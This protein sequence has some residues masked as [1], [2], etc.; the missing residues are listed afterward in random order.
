MKNLSI[1]FSF[2]FLFFLTG[3]NA[4]LP[5]TLTA[6]KN[7]EEAG[8]SSEGLKKLDA[9]FQEVI[10]K[11]IAPNIV[12]FIAKKGKIVHFKAFGYSNLETKTALKKDDIFRIASQ[13]KAITTVGLLMLFEEGKFFLDEPI[14]KYIPAFKNPKVLVSYDEK[15][16]QKYI[17]RPA[18]SEITIRQLLSHSAGIPYEHAL[19]NLPEFKVPFYC[20]TEK[21]L[22]KDVVDK[23]AA[24]PLVADPGTKFVYGLNTDVLGR[25]IEILSGMPFDEYL[26]KKVLTPLGMNDTY[27]YLPNSKAPRLVEL[28]SKE[29]RNDDLTV[30]DNDTYR[31][32]AVSGA[33][34]YLSGGAGL[35]STIEDYAKFCQFLLNKGEFNGKRLLSRSTVDMMGRN[36]IGESFVWDRQDKFGLGLQI[37]TP[38]SRY[39]DNATPS[40]LTWGGM[41]CSEYTIDQKEKT[42]MLVFTNVHPY[43]YYSDIVRKFR[44]LAYQAML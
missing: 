36:Q 38:E 39:G 44:I 24:R 1:L 43:A 6:A 42:I 12:T 16:P 19:Q 41:Y 2:L 37:I 17:T 13:S 9:H 34:T 28:Y 5:Q 4:Q 21:E 14:S 30:H 26:R 22:L 33:K 8:F 35:L 3:V 32:F 11:G 18:K 23:I 15:D 20:S 10:D 7:P 29:N 27:F 25:L 31:K 40:S